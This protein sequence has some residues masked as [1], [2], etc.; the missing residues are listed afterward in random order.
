[1]DSRQ[2]PVDAALV[3][4]AAAAA[5]EPPVALIVTATPTEQPI[6]RVAFCPHCGNR[7]PQ[8]LVH[9]QHYKME[10]FGEDDEKAD[11]YPFI[12]F[13]ARCETCDEILVYTGP[14]D[15]PEDYRKDFTKA[16]RLVYPSPRTFGEEVPEPIRRCYSEASSVK[17]GSPNAYAVLIR[18][19]LEALCDDRGAAGQV[20]HGRLEDLAKR[21][22]LPSVLAQMTDLLRLLGNAGAHDWRST[23]RPSQVWAMDEFFRAVVEYIYV[24]PAMVKAFRETL[25]KIKNAGESG[26]SQ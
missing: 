25:T 7:A 20:L 26:K 14:A 22:E 18:R 8:E 12:Y 5:G 15:F 6:R 10:F 2:A 4:G 11:E 19:A 13:V 23:V 17:H 16:S 21:G 1:V 24:A 3:V 9:V